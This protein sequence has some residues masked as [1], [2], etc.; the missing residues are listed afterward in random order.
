MNREGENRALSAVLSSVLGILNGKF[1]I[2]V[3]SLYILPRIARVVIRRYVLETCDYILE[4][5]SE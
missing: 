5:C 3:C 4:T 2:T 1:E